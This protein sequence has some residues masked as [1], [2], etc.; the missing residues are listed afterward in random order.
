MNNH[1]TNIHAELDEYIEQFITTAELLP[2]FKLM[3]ND[4]KSQMCS[5]PA[6]IKNHHWWPGGYTDHIW[7][8][9]R[10]SQ[11]FI[12]EGII[13]ADQLPFTRED[14]FI[15]CYVHDLD[16]LE[17]YIVGTEKPSS[18]QMNYARNLGCNISANETKSTISGKIDAAINGSF[19]TVKPFEMDPVYTQ[20]PVDESAHVQNILSRYNI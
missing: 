19:L 6:G 3:H 5:L 8:V 13:E 1:L 7:E 20:T 12:D 14:L 9:C 15:I 16:K 11:M 17:R 2:K 18:A 4:L 10:M